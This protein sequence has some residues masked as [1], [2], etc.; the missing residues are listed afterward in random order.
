M[1]LTRRVQQLE[2]EL[3]VWKQARTATVEQAD[4][5]KRQH[6]DEKAGLLRRIANLEMQQVLLSFPL[7]SQLGY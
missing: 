1:A 3:S 4:R 2:E 7:N 6:E 5:D